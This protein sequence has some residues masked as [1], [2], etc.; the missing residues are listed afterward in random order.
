MALKST[1]KIETNLYEIE[2]DASKESFDAAVEKVYRKEVKKITL[3][4][5]KN[6]IAFTAAETGVYKFSGYTHTAIS[7]DSDM[8][9]QG[10][11]AR[12]V[13]MYANRRHTIYFE[14]PNGAKEV[15]IAFKGNP[16]EEVSA[17]VY[18]HKGQLMGQW[19][20]VVLRTPFRHTR[21]FTGPE[22]WR[23]E[24]SFM[25]EDSEIELG[26]DL[27]PVFALTPELLLRAK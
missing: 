22:I 2:F 12:R 13:G 8:P 3:A 23:I 5:G 1:N 16:G 7:F 9:G 14:V 25:R 24:I 4:A 27:N 18:N 6:N 11:D 19:N 21:V 20:N 17:K 15:M 26:G 10:I